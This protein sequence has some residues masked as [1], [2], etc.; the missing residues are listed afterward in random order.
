[1]LGACNFPMPASMTIASGPGS[2][3]CLSASRRVEAITP[4]D[5]IYS[6]R[7][8]AG[9]PDLGPPPYFQRGNLF[10]IKCIIYITFLG[11]GRNNREV[12]PPLPSYDEATKNSPSIR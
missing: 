4:D 10:L 2:N 12:L 6:F 5:R 1:M 8:V 9:I 11:R 3:N 7:P